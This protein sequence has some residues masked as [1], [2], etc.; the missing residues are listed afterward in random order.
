MLFF[1]KITQDKDLVL[2]LCHHM[3]PWYML[4]KFDVDL[5]LINVVVKVSRNS[6]Q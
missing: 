1:L 2:F 5:S 6:I 4:A 3:D